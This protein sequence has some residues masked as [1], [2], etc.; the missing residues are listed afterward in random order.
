MLEGLT[1]NDKQLFNS[2]ATITRAYQTDRC[3]RKITFNTHKKRSPPQKLLQN[4][5]IKRRSRNRAQLNYF[6]DVPSENAAKLT[7]KETGD[8]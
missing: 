6:V 2:L 4:R 7:T 1:K 8:K 3:G 5:A